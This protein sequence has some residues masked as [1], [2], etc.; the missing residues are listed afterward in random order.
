MK[1]ILFLGGASHQTSI[2]NHAKKNYFIILC[3]N[4][5]HCIG[6]KYA[7]KFYKI[8]IKNKNKILEISRKEKINAI[9]SYASEIGAL[10]QCYVA[11]KLKLPSN[12]YNSIK[13]LHYKNKTVTSNVKSNYLIKHKILE[14]GF[15][16]DGIILS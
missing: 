2:L 13:T 14:K 4:D 6:K 3:D 5:S 1:K 8:S 16:S 7:D 11:N 15:L 12:N 9:I 10:T